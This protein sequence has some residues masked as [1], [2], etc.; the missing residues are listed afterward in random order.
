MVVNPYLLV[1][2]E[3][4]LWKYPASC[5]AAILCAAPNARQILIQF[6][7]SVL[8]RAQKLWVQLE[9]ENCALSCDS[10]FLR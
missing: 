2:N 1:S 9:V 6:F 4:Q 3:L 10:A 7:T 5:G 8:I